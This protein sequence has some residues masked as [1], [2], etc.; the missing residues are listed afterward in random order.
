M[1]IMRFSFEKKGIRESKD[2]R[3]KRALKALKKKVHAIQVRDLRGRG[4]KKY[5]GGAA[6]KARLILLDKKTSKQ[7]QYETVM[8]EVGHFKLMEKGNPPLGKKAMQELR[9]T[10]MYQQY[11]KEG[12][13][14][15]EIPREAFARYYSQKKRR[16]MPT[17]LKKFEDKYPNLVKKFKQIAK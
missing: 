6:Y 2:P 11:K 8:H 3:V 5:I 16:Y 13:T 7:D 9:K 1:I 17:Q 4:N 15:N 10:K 14:S 12:Y